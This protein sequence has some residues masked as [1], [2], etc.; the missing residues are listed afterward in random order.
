M[1]IRWLSLCAV[2]I[3]VSSSP[4]LAAAPSTVAA[5]AETQNGSG[6]VDLSAGYQR[7][8]DPD[9]SYMD[10]DPAVAGGIDPR[11]KP[12]NPQ[13]LAVSAARAKGPS[14][15]V[16]NSTQNAYLLSLRGDR[17]GAEAGLATAKQRHPDSVGVHWSEG[18]IRLNL[19]DFEGALVAW[20]QAQRLHGG[21]PFWVP[22]TKSIALMGLGDGEAAL[23]WWQVAQ[24]AYAPELATANA[25]RQ[26]FQHWRPTEKMLLEEVID[27]AY[28]D[29][30]KVASD[31][32][33]LEMIDTPLPH[34]PPELVS[35]GVQGETLVRIQV[36][37]AGLAVDVKVEKS[38]GYAGMDAE[39]LRVAR[40][41]RFKVPAGT[42]PD[43]LW[44]SVP[45][46][47]SLK[48]RPLAPP[49]PARKAEIDRIIA[50]RMEEM[51]A[52]AA[53]V[54]DQNR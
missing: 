15:D 50:Q 3:G 45:Y 51:R 54:E 16:R 49:N 9:S 12:W 37:A 43:G 35:S 39:A 11:W 33:G 46:R 41:T 1:S 23:A 20:Q 6:F 24:R 19:L 31:G 25:A 13:H 48:P 21:S 30:R 2:L 36:D 4:T 17:A 40:L 26:R 47:F 5:A 34:Y 10:G 52:E 32:S 14:A 29:D 28:P 22:Y 44:A 8:P 18:W 42:G 7:L 53:K 27:L 38:S